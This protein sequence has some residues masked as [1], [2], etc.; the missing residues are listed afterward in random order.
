[1]SKID[2]KA[3]AVSEDSDNGAD[4]EAGGPII[5]FFIAGLV[6][7]LIIGW[8]IF[9]KVLYS[10]KEQPINFN[11]V[12]HVGE[13]ED[14]CQSCHYFREDGSFSGIPKLASCVECHEEVLGETEEEAKF[15]AQ[16]VDKERRFPGWS[17]QDSPTAYFSRMRPM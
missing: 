5:L 3:Q 9:P 14:G 15:I 2:E 17:I 1:M 7:S 11:H 12:L 4:D 13:V 16:Y 10:Q 6:A 8:V